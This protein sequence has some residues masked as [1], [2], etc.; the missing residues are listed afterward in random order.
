VT[1][2]TDSQLRCYELTPGTGASGIQTVSAGS[3]VSFTIDPD[4]FHP[5]P[6]SFYMA[7]VPSGQTAATFTG[8]GS[9]W[10]KIWE[11][12]PTFTTDGMVWSS[13]GLTE[14]TVTIPSCLAPGDYLLRVEHIALHSASSLGGAQVLWMNG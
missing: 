2:V 9:V 6:L 8:D 13:N 1:D 4:I 5:G 10:F 11:E 14:A 7:K 3:T 12:H